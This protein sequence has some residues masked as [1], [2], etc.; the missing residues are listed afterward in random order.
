MFLVNELIYSF[1][2]NYYSLQR[3]YNSQ[4]CNFY[5]LQ[6]NYFYSL[7]NHIRETYRDSTIVVCMNLLIIF[8]EPSRDNTVINNMHCLIRF[9]RPPETDCSHH[10]EIC[11]LFETYKIEPMHSEQSGHKYH[12]VMQRHENN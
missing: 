6:Y 8:K 10:H 11:K 3:I 5:S 12:I 4:Q 9:E 1:K 7:S 2:H